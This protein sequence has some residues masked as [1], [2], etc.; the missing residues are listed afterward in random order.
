[1]DAVTAPVDQSTRP[2]FGR[3]FSASAQ[4]TLSRLRRRFP[5]AFGQVRPLKVGIHF[6]IID[7]TDMDSLIVV[8]FMSFYSQSAAYLRAQT[9]P[10]AMRYD[11]DGNPVEPVSEANRAYAVAQLEW[12]QG[13]RRQEQHWRA[14]RAALLEPVAITEG[15]EQ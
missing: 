9:Q 2:P 15:D 11:L 4:H 7:R 10:G 3:D 8:H 1:V 14:F 6:D 12:V 5:G 13:Q